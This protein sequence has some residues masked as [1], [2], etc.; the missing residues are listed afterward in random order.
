MDHQDLVLALSSYI[1][2]PFS[3]VHNLPWWFQVT[4]SSLCIIVFPHLFAFAYVPSIGFLMVL[5][6][7]ARAFPLD[8]SPFLTSSPSF[9]GAL[10]HTSTTALCILNYNSLFTCVLCNTM[11]SLRIGSECASHYILG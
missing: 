5:Q 9:H 11:G 7:A 6:T 1:S 8:I 10:G 3:Y 4:Y 2:G